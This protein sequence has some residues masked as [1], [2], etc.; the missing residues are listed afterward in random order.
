[1]GEERDIRIAQSCARDARAAVAELHEGISQPGM[2]LVL[3][4]CSSHY[5]REALAAA[6]ARRSPACPLSA[7]RPPAR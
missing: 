1:M 3:F 6:I 7:A 2:S 4:F 5:D